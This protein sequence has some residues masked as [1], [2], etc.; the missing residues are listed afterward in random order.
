MK[1]TV[2]QIAVL[3]TGFVIAISSC[4]KDDYLIGGHL[5]NAKVNVSTYDYL[6]NH[7][8]H[9]FDTLIMIVDKA[10][11]KSVLN[12]KDITFFAPTDFSINAYLNK[13]ALEEQAI[14]PHRNYTLDSFYK[15]D[16]SKFKDSIK[17]YIIN[18]P[19]SY[20]DLTEKGQV[21]QTAKPGDSVVISFEPTHDVDLG[22]YGGVSTIPHIMYFI[23]LIAPL[24]EPFNAADI[25]DDVGIRVRCQ[26]TGIQT[27]TGMLEVLNN[28]HTLFFHP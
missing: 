24:S 22:Y 17:G 20:K 25:P 5:H 7:P 12:Q 18:Q 15:Y 14:D 11:M 13:K 28:D 21:Y 3:L 23:H 6:K 8:Y 26:T 9:L 4:K 19:L 1:K 10:G 16:L 2:L 27:T